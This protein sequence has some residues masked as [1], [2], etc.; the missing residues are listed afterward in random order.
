MKKGFDNIIAFELYNNSL[1][2]FEKIQIVI[3]VIV[4]TN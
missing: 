4:V 1:P 3:E 2:Q